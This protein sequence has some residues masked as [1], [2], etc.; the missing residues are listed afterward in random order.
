MF[1]QLSKM[2]TFSFYIMSACSVL[3]VIC[4]G[5]GKCLSLCCSEFMYK[6]NITCG[7][8]GLIECVKTFKLLESY[9]VVMV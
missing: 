2:V 5:R 3:T 8:F 9:L 4:T 6:K 7:Y 1:S